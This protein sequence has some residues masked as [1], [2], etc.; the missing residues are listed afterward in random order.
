[1]LLGFAKSPRTGPAWPRHLDLLQ[2]WEHLEQVGQN[3]TEL[4][5]KHCLHTV[6]PW[7]LH[8]EEARVKTRVQKEQLLQHLFILQTCLI[9]SCLG[10]EPDN[11][12]HFFLKSGFSEDPLALGVAFFATLFQYFF[13]GPLA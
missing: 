9:E 1:M 10:T 2:H 7:G 5:K 12:C 6:D 4:Q 8:P 11:N 3:L 13:S